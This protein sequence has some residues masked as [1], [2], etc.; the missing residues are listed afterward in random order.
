MEN[1][2]PKTNPDN[3]TELSG[4]S[5]M[6]IVIVFFLI[7][8]SPF[9]LLFFIYYILYSLVLA[10]K[11]KLSPVQVLTA[12]VLFKSYCRERFSF[13]SERYGFREAP[14]AAYHSGRRYEEIFLVRYLSGTYFLEISSSRHGNRLSITLGELTENQTILHLFA[15]EDILAFLDPSHVK[16]HKK[17]YGKNKKPLI[18]RIDHYAANLEVHGKEIF[19][20]SFISKKADKIPE[21][22][23]KDTLNTRIKPECQQ[24]EQ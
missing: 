12:P 1:S 16:I 5:F 18:R 2:N 14:R 15:V 21:L 10:I 17:V 24:N 20:P 11:K 8:L 23:H 19:N 3:N 7:L 13:L 6:G 9:I 4:F 22:L